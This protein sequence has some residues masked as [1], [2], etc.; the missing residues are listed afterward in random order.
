[1]VGKGEKIVDKVIAYF[2]VST[3]IPVAAA[4]GC[5]RLRSSRQSC[6]FNLSGKPRCL[7]YDCC[8]VE[9]SLRQLLPGGGGVM[10]EEA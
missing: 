8:A 10:A 1:V 6:N 5:V 2:F 3:Q 7:I 9:R 4:E